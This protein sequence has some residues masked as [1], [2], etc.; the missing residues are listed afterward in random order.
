MF[1]SVKSTSETFQKRTSAFRTIDIAYIAIGVALMAVCSWI[2]IP[3][4]IPFTLQTFAVFVSVCLLGGFRGTIAVLVYLLLGAAG[5]PVFAE[6]HGGM[7][8]LLG[9][10]GGYL[11]GFLFS[12]LVMWAFEKMIGKKI[13]M[14]AISMVLALI[15]CYAFGTVWFAKVYVGEDGSGVS[16]MTALSWCVFPYILPDLA[17]IAVALL[18]GS[19]KALRRVIRNG[20]NA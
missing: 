1:D 11:V 6:M 8:S 5:A 15:V 9:P 4:T 14:Y 19:N 2:S 3:T 13:W 17:K 16:M 12:A 18:I 10:T 20:E 7:S